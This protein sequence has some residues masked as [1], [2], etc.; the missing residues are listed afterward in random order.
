[1]AKMTGNTYFPA[2]TARSDL[3]GTE[4]ST[5][6]H[7]SEATI[8]RP[9]WVLVCVFLMLTLAAIL[10]ELHIRGIEHPLRDAHAFVFEQSSFE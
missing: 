4:S 5:L 9:S 10:I 8:P 6:L 1:M 7:G 2:G 3:V